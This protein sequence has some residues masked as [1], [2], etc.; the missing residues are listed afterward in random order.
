MSSPN[1]YNAVGAGETPKL[2]RGPVKASMAM[3]GSQQAATPRVGYVDKGKAS[4]SRPTVIPE[5]GNGFAQ[6]NLGSAEAEQTGIGSPRPGGSTTP[7]VPSPGG[8]F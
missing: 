1:S 2:G 7:I 5:A 3:P 4:G 8:E 6:A